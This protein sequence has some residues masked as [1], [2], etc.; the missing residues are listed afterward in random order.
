M[1][2]QLSESLPECFSSVGDFL[3]CWGVQGALLHES[4]EQRWSSMLPRCPLHMMSINLSCSWSDAVYLNN[5]TKKRK[6]RSQMNL[7]GNKNTNPTQ[8]T[9]GQNLKYRYKS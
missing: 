3:V 7:L 9:A 5:Q 8:I 4:S 6:D 1:S 2:I